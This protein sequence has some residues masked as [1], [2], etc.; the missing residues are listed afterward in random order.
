M[1][2]KIIKKELKNY[3]FYILRLPG[4]FGK[5][6]KPNYNS[7]V[8]T[9][10]ITSLEKKIK[11]EDPNK[12][13]HLVHIDDVV[14]KI[15][16]IIENSPNESQIKVSPENKINVKDLS[17]ILNKFYQ[18]RKNFLIPNA[19]KGFNRALYSTFISYL[20]ES[21]FGYKVNIKEDKRGKFCELLKG[22]DNG[23]I[24]FLT[25]NPGFKRGGHYH[26][27][28]TEKFIVLKG[29]VKFFFSNLLNTNTIE[30]YSSYENPE[31]V[32]SIP[33]W[34]HELE[35]IGNE[36]ALVLL[37]ANEIY[38]VKNHDTFYPENN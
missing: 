22:I 14:S 33:G 34:F 7:V 25:I 10:V 6:C 26:N 32:D 3:P 18:D 19:A 21:K 15:I 1:A 23:Q 28:K 37:W 9:F 11:I 38:D 5:W 16:Y 27:T 31:I 2:E 30:I 13:L 35:N 17:T 29:K 12:E 36:E 8:A 24:S 4:V 20:P